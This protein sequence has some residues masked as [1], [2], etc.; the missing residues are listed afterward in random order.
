MKGTEVEL[1]S[2]EPDA[3]TD[4][5][6]NWVKF[7]TRAVRQRIL[8]EELDEMIHSVG[9]LEGRLG[10]PSDSVKSKE[11]TALARREEAR[12]AY[13]HDISLLHDLLEKFVKWILSP[14]EALQRAPATTATTANDAGIDISF[15]TSDPDRSFNNSDSERRNLL[16]LDAPELAARLAALEQ[17]VGKQIPQVRKAFLLETAEIREG[18][19]KIRTEIKLMSAQFEEGLEDRFSG[20][21]Q[22]MGRS[23][24][25]ER[26]EFS[27]IL[28][29]IDALERSN[30]RLSKEN[31]EL[32]Q[33]VWKMEKEMYKQAGSIEQLESE[34]KQV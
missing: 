3:V 17:R 23:G 32:K 33:D 25:V 12:R 2:S 15:S 9:V 19:E 18:V 28:Q 11:S 6:R 22:N 7:S 13:A 16:P 24:G 8:Y 14:I 5:V 21:Q 31:E 20:L 27:A 34:V 10:R 26:E 1:S 30:Q 29:R 4:F